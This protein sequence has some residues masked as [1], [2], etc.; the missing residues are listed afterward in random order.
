M[1]S[2]QKED[3]R[4]LS[5]LPLGNPKT[6]SAWAFPGLP[7][8]C[9]LL[10]AQPSGS[11]GNSRGWFQGGKPTVKQFAQHPSH[12]EPIPPDTPI[13]GGRLTSAGLGHSLG[14][15]EDPSLST[16][17]SQETSSWDKARVR[18]ALGPVPAVSYI[19]WLWIRSWN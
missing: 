18:K 6:G 12:T 5:R 19:W 1:L 2:P 3:T 15:G 8:A 7:R 13:K 4:Y 9:P 10:S 16:Q 11:P 14:E 17:V